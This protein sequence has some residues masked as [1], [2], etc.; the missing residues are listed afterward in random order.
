MLTERNGEKLLS[1]DKIDEQGTD[2]PYLLSHC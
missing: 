1:E 2:R